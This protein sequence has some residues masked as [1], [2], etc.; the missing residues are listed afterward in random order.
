MLLNEETENI[1]DNYDPIYELGTRDN[2]LE[3][4]RQPLVKNN[5]LLAFYH[6]YIIIE[7]RC[8][9][10]EFKF[11]KINRASHN[12]CKV[13]IIPLPDFT[14]CKDLGDLEHHSENYF[15][16]LFSLFRISSWPRRKVINNPKKKMSPFL[17]VIREEKVMKSIRHL[18]LGQSW[19]LNDQNVDKFDNYY[20]HTVSSVEA[21][22]FWTNGR[23]EEKQILHLIGEN[24]AESTDFD[25]SDD[26]DYD[27][28]DDGSLN[29]ME[30]EPSTTKNNGIIDKI[31]FIDEEIFLLK[32][33]S[34]NESLIPGTNGDDQLSMQELRQQLMK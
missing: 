19:I 2:D 26:D 4:I 15:W 21:V 27:Y 32:I 23:W 5:S 25:Y 1:K 20:S 14:V 11:Q 13:Y 3:K 12:D 18:K 9:D 30:I 33:D 29:T 7:T 16:F 17:R 28:D 22:F 34:Y 24:L 8:K 6:A 10:T 31:S